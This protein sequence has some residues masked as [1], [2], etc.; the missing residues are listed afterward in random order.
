MKQLIKPIAVFLIILSTGTQAFAQDMAAVSPAQTNNILTTTVESKG[1]ENAAK[2]N[3]ST[4]FPNASQQKWSIA[5]GN[6]FVSFLNNGRKA[7]ASF[8][9]KGNMNY[10]ITNCE[11]N[12]LPEDFSKSIKSNYADYKLFHAIEIKAYGET[13]YQAVMESATNFITLKFTNDGVEEIQTVK[14]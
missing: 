6:N 11:L 10:V 4:L 8:T 9:A 3:F 14:K 1:A 5:A 13:A 12:N 2:T 7:T